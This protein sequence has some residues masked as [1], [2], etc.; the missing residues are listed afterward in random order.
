MKFRPTLSASVSDSRVPVSSEL[1][2]PL[3]MGSKPSSPAKLLPREP[4]GGKFAM[5][6]SA[7]PSTGFDFDGDVED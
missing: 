5:G 7:T 6:A 1:I 3:N 2:V 4:S